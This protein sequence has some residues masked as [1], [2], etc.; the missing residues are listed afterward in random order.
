MEEELIKLTL[1]VLQRN[2]PFSDLIIEVDA[3]VNN[4]CRGLH[5]VFGSSRQMLTTIVLP[6]LQGIR[7]KIPSECLKA[8]IVLNLI[9]TKFFPIHT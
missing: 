5:Q 4:D 2:R 8:G 7:F 1:H 9:Q 3:G 6:Y